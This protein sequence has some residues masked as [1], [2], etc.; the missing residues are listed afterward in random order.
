MF[1]FVILAAASPVDSDER[2]EE[3]VD[4]N[5]MQLNRIFGV[6]VA[7]TENVLLKLHSYTFFLQECLILEP[8]LNV[9]FCTI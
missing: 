4:V 7:K 1:R 8:R 3:N 9:M 2:R 6:T 5:E